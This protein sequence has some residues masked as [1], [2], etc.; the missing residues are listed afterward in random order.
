MARAHHCTDLCFTELLS[1]QA[2]FDAFAF[3]DVNSW[4]LQYLHRRAKIVEIVACQGLIFSLAQSGACAAFDRGALLRHG[5]HALLLHSTLARTV[6]PHVLP[7]PSS[8]PMCPRRH[9]GASSQA[10]LSRKFRA[11]NANTVSSALAQRLAR[12]YAT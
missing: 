4:R 7:D 2:E 8:N 3:G 6:T 1:A 11:A 12:G 9:L 10:C 5:P